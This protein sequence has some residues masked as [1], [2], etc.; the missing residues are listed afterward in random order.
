MSINIKNKEAE[1]LLAVLRGAT[2]KGT[3][4]L[5]LELLRAEH[6]RLTR[7]EQDAAHAR[8]N[9]EDDRVRRALEAT[10]ELQ[11]LWRESPG[12]SG[13]SRKGSRT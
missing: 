9:A 2:G 3:S 13:E 1:H 8:D 7:Q 4:Q 11:T 6:A 12:L 5:I 10:R